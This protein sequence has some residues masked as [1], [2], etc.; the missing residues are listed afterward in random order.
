MSL[1]GLL[2]R[3][4]A[5]L[6]AHGIPYMITGSVAAG[7]HGFERTTRDID[8]VI[9]PTAR[10]LDA[11]CADME[12]A[13]VYVSAEV[14]REALAT[15]GMFNVIDGESGWKADLIVR[16]ERPVSRAEFERRIRARLGDT[17][18]EVAAAEDVILSKLEWARLGAS[19]RQLDDV[20][21]LLEQ[22]GEDIDRAYIE[23]W[24]AALGLQTE[25][26]QADLR[27]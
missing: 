16:K 7:I 24:V 10:A 22:V 19:T 3:V 9:D 21:S 18:I 2:R 6:D 15:R 23:H 27:R 11:F 17:V 12:R 4:V 5:A 8:I 14:A 26:R 1:G 25:W 20:R 13:G